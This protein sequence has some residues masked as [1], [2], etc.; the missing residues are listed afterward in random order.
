MPG[1]FTAYEV[2]PAKKILVKYNAHL[3]QVGDTWVVK[4]ACLSG[5]LDGKQLILLLLTIGSC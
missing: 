4:Q 3:L 2:E 1:K 5:C